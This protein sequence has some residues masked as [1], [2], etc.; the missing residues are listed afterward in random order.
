MP[1]KLA[2]VVAGRQII[3]WHAVAERRHAEAL[4]GF[5]TGFSMLTLAREQATP[6]RI[7]RK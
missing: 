7:D 3:G 4:V 2:E 5:C 6:V 1:L